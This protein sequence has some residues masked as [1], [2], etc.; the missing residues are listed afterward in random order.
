MKPKYKVLVYNFLGFAALFILFRFGLTLI[1]ELDA[2]YMAL[3]AALMASLLAPKFAVV[4]K[5]SIEKILM[6][7]IFIRGFKE[8]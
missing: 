7:W 1:L 2:F 6:K 3:I 8:L 4:K 5:E